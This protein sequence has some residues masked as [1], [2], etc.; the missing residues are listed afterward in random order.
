METNVM[1]VIIALVMCGSAVGIAVVICDMVKRVDSRY[2][3]HR[4]EMKKAEQKVLE[5]KNRA[6]EI[7]VE[8]ERRLLEE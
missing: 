7:E 8:H 1:Y 4:L 3:A 2:Q 5:A 6:R